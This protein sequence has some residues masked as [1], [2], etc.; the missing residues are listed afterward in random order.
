M[1]ILVLRIV[2]V[3]TLIIIG[4]FC[5]KKIW[6]PVKN[7]LFGDFKLHPAEETPKER[8]KSDKLRNLARDSKR[9]KLAPLFSKRISILK[10]VRH[11]IVVRMRMVMI[12]RRAARW[13]TQLELIRSQGSG[14]STLNISW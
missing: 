7:Q 1:K 11:V 5:Q 4:L 8:G 3:V 9:E 13:R 10:E 14:A 2:A 6:A 12:V